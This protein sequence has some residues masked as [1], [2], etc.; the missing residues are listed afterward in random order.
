MTE[1]LEKTTAAENEEVK[2]A[3]EKTEGKKKKKSRKKKIVKRLFWMLIILLVLGVALWS[4]ISKLQSEYRITYDPYT[5]TT[6]SISNSLSFTGSMQLVN[7]ANYTASEDTKVR[8][9]YVAE[10]D[11]VSEGDKLM[12]LYGGDTI[13]AEFDGTV[14]SIDVEKGDEVKSGDSLLTV[15]DFDHMKVSVRI[16]ESNIGQVTKGQSCRVTVSSAGATFDATIDNID[17]VSYT[18]NNVAYYTGTVNVDTSG[19]DNIWPGMQTTVTVPLEEAENVTV[20]KM[21]ALSTARNNTAYVY[22]ETEDGEMEEVTVTVGVSNGNYVEIKDGVTAG[23][24]VYKIAEKEEEA[25]GLAALFSGIFTNRQVNRPNRN[26]NSQGGS[27]EFDFS[28]MPDMSNMPSGFG[29]GSGFPGGGSG[30]SGF[31]GGGSR[32]N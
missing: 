14:S 24:T 20:L 25:T 22:K 10:G 4:V 9:I 27:N 8:E 6:G 30:G 16:G 7:S 2:A 26:R 1:I 11:K 18:G 32:G 28:N 29:G 5:A 23:E 12:R 21:E 31:P 15:A 19:T 3:A 17:Y 13:E